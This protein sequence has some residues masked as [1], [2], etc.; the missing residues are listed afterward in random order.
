M[1]FQGSDH[2]LVQRSSASY[3]ATVSSLRDYL[4]D[5]GVGATVS[6]S[7]TPPALSNGGDLWYNTEDGTLY[8]YYVDVNSEQWVP[9]Y[10][11][12]VASGEDSPVQSVNNKS[13]QVVL[14][15][16]DIS[17]GA[18]KYSRWSFGGGDLFYTGGNIGVGTG[19]PRCPLI[20][21]TPLDL[22]LPS[23]TALVRFP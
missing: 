7:A 21:K 22:R 14:T 16:D 4:V 13:G 18:L 2:V 17:E 11:S 12:G 8:I 23:L 10:A 15:T 3:K 20:F 19:T 9:S 1:A 6:S 5:Q